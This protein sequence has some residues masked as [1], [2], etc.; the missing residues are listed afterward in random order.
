MSESFDCVYEKAAST[1]TSFDRRPLVTFPGSGAVKAGSRAAHSMES[2]SL[3]RAAIACTLR[4]SPNSPIVCYGSISRP[5]GPW[6]RH[7][8]LKLTG[9]VEPGEPSVAYP[10]QMENGLVFFVYYAFPAASL[11]SGL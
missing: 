11:I 2:D 9:K 7:V 10:S 5:S 8:S 6:A 3:E 1:K 4:D